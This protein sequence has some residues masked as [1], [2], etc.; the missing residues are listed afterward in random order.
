MQKIT[1]IGRLGKDAASAK[2]ASGIS[3]WSSTMACNSRVRG[4]EKTTWFD[5]VSFNYRENFVKILKKGALVVVV[6]DLDI[7]T[8]TSKDGQSHP[9]LSVMVDSIDFA[10]PAKNDTT[11]QSE[12]AEESGQPEAPAAAPKKKAAPAPD[13]EEDSDIP[14]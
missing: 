4:E 9:K 12:S 1:L 10:S 3:Y 8:Y 14:F 13:P 5:L 11:E 6:G 7:G 2:T